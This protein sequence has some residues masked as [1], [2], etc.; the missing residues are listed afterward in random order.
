M[1]KYEW[2]KMNDEGWMMN[3]EWWM[4]MISS[5]WGVLQTDKRTNE[6]TDI[7][8]CRVTFATENCTHVWRHILSQN[9]HSRYILDHI[10]CWELENLI[11]NYGL[12][13]SWQDTDSFVICVALFLTN[14]M[15]K[16]DRAFQRMKLDT[17]A[18]MCY[19]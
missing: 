10:Y 2:S 3:D 5:S 8:D 19:P 18:T 14:S 4:M 15:I 6:R 1:M 7:Y 9:L 12:K 16:F 13:I 17:V 11:W